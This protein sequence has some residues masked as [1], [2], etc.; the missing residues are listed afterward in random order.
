VA[1]SVKQF[2]TI[3][4]LG[5]VT[6]PG[7]Y[8]LKGNMTVVE[9]LAMAG[10]L[11]DFS[12]ATD[13]KVIRNQEGSKINLNVNIEDVTKRGDK[14][15]DIILEPNDVIVVA[16]ISKISILGQ[17]VKPGS[18][19]LKSNMT[20][21]QAIATA[22]GFSKYA[23]PNGTKI[24]RSKDGKEVTL[25]VRVKDI[26]ERGDKSKDILLEPGDVVVVPESF[27]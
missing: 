15:K 16:E 1:V 10:G 7:T 2:N 26:T 17:V 21:V 24:I 6:K 14:S 20:I 27:F 4:I 12:D 13:V 3:S 5:Q 19:E 18:Y 11:N 9:A 25:R 23:N 22:G 8:E